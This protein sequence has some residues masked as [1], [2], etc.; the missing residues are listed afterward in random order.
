[1][2][3][4]FYSCNCE[5]YCGRD[6]QRLVRE[7]L[8]YTIYT[9]SFILSQKYVYTKY[10]Q[11]AKKSQIHSNVLAILWAGINTIFP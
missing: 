2:R 10:R 8:D 4:S 9:L 5:K 11:F 7:E 1:M 6:V 3:Y